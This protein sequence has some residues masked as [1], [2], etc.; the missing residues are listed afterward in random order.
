M[1]LINPCNPAVN[2]IIVYIILILIVVIIK[3]QFLYGYRDKLR[4]YDNKDDQNMIY[5]IPFGILISILLYFIFA[6][7]GNLNCQNRIKLR[8]LMKYS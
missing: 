1:G 7:I 4:R 6:Y 5:L 8:Y 2:A 3:P